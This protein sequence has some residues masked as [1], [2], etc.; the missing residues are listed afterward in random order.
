MSSYILPDMVVRVRVGVVAL[1]GIDRFLA[2]RSLCIF[3]KQGVN[4]TSLNCLAE[5]CYMLCFESLSQLSLT[6]PFLI[7]FTE[8]FTTIRKLLHGLLEKAYAAEAKVKQA[9]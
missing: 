2:P 3:Q 9:R 7:G 4:E 8:N 1:V 5:R 6:L